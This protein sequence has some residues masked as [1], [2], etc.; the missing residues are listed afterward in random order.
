MNSAKVTVL[1]PT[2]NRAKFLQ[3]CLQSIL[4]QTLPPHQVIVVN[5]GSTD[6]TRAVLEPFMQQ[7]VYLE[8]SHFGKS[9]AVNH[10]LKSVTGEYLWIFDDDDVAL[11]DALERFVAPLQANPAYGF[12]FSTCFYSMTD[13]RT[14]RIGQFL[15]ESSIPDLVTRGFLA[16]MLEEDFIGGAAIFARTDCYHQVGNFKPSLLRS[17]DYDMAIRIARKFHGA[18][19]PGSAT[20][21]YRQHSGPRGSL[22]D[23]F[24]AA[25]SLN[26]WLEYDQIIFRDLYGSL[27]LTEVLPPG[28]PLMGNERLALL[29]RMGIMLSKLLF[30]EA[31]SDLL[32]LIETDDSRNFSP[33]EKLVIQVIYRRS[34]RTVLQHPD[35]FRELR[36]HCRFSSFARLLRREFASLALSLLFSR[37]SPL[38]FRQ[39]LAMLSGLYGLQHRLAANDSVYQISSRKF[40]QNE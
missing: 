11:P 20:Y 13:E 5:D 3:E 16:P 19:V 21:H 37:L 32:A 4:A 31:F 6:H 30:K 25:D 40:I 39:S 29:Q 33:V 27:Y 38:R 12:S 10:G 35:F 23:R 1:I 7:I 22:K 9:T 34:L 18:R 24:D 28:L 26:K 8:T 15:R 36:R 17:Q 14:G 2:F